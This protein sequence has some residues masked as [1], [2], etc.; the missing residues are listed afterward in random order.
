M[1]FSSLYFLSSLL[2]LLPLV[3][4]SEKKKE[5]VSTTTTPCTPG[6]GDGLSSENPIVICDYAGLKAI[7]SG[8]DSIMS[9]EG[10]SMHGPVGAKGRISMAAPCIPT[11]GMRPQK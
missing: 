1:K 3:S 2:L 11:M 7:D 5:T 4:C 8:L 6:I 10:I 9:L